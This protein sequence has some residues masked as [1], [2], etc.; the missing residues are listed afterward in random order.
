MLNPLIRTPQDQT[1]LERLYQT[2]PVS[3]PL[4]HWLTKVRSLFC[5][6]PALSSGG[7]RLEEKVI[8]AAEL[9]IPEIN[10]FVHSLEQDRAV[11]LASLESPW[12]TA[13]RRGR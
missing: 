3:K 13:K 12:T 7:R 6:D 2:L 11:I 8:Q 10:R 4:H 9:K 1:R 5:S